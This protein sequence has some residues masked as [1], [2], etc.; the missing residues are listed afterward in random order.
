MLAA[1][2]AM[3]EGQ[4]MAGSIIN[5]LFFLTVLMGY[6]S[7]TTPYWGASIYLLLL[8]NNLI[9]VVSGSYIVNL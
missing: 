4:K 5:L 8:Y 9:K 3:T 1:K 2:I 6:T 7:E